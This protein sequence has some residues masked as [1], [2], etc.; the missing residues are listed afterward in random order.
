MSPALDNR[1]ILIFFKI[2]HIRLLDTIALASE[3][4]DSFLFSIP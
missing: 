3:M 2:S 1:G 4:H